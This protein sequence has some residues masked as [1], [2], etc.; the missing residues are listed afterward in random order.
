M[1][2]PDRLGS[3]MMFLRLTAVVLWLVSFW[4]AAVAQDEPQSLPTMPL[5]IE[6]RGGERHE[7]TV[8][9]ADDYNEQR[10][11]MMHREHVADDAGMLF[12]YKYP[13]PLSFWMKN[14][15]IPLDILYVQSDGR[16]A[17]IAEETT[18]LSLDS[19]PSKG[20]VLAALELRGGLSKALGIQPGDKVLHP[21]FGTAA[22]SEQ[23]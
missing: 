19:I 9:I 7:F 20:R 15:L 8:E 16:I 6:T 12:V 5:A 2:G 13:Q 14:T 21:I 18:P 1:L 11:G 22:K 17:N 23:E 10:I 3:Y 4:G